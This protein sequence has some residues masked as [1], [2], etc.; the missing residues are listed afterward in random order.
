M[1]A[2]R[3]R[4]AGGRVF[5]L[6]A[7]SGLITGLSANDVVLAWRWPATEVLQTL[8]YL[9]LKW[10]TVAGF[11]TAQELALAAHV[12]TSFGAANFTGGTDLS[13]P[14]SNP[15]YAN[16][17]LPLDSSYSYVVPGTKSQLVA[18]NVRIATT[19][20]L[21]QGAA[22]TVKS[23][24]FLWDE[25]S[26]LAASA[27]THKGIMDLVYA[28]DRDVDDALCFGGDAGFIVRTPIALGAAGTGRLSVEAVWH[29]R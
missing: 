23:Q 21:T 4:I 18:G 6:A 3:E 12:V 5:R 13:D 1:S 15:A 7:T 27:S 2:S 29:E 8:L 9:S 26:E 10:R 25:F 16:T 17:E 14:A 11:T 22:P 24:P 28:P 19:G 20:T